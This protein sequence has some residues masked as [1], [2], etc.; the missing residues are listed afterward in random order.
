[1]IASVTALVARSLEPTS[2]IRR[3]GSVPSNNALN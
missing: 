2:K 3:D 1:M